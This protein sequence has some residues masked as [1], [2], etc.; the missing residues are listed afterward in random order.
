LRWVVR[1]GRD[2]WWSADEWRGVAG[3]VDGS[4]C[5]FSPS[6]AAA[7]DGG[8]TTLPDGA[9]LAAAKAPTGA[10]TRRR[11]TAPLAL[12]SPTL[13]AP[14]GVAERTSRA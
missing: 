4:N 10:T 8:R 12:P 3:R 2:E 7:S 13:S 9:S 5:G 1:R 6:A 14:L 11:R